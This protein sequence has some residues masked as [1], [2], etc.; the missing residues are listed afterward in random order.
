MCIRDRS[1][2]ESRNSKGNAIPVSSRNPSG[3]S[4]KTNTKITQQQQPHNLSD[5]S[6]LKVPNPEKN[7]N[8]GRR[9]KNTSYNAENNPARS[10]RASVMVSTL[11]EEDGSAWSNNG[12]NNIEVQTSTARKVLN[13]FKRRSM[14]V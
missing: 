3:Q 4:N 14:R 2:V 13:F 10:V 12:D 8:D 7:T 11:R 1:T 5:S 6:I 9:R